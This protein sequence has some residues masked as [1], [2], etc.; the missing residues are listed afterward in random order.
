M[1]DPIAS[2]VGYSSTQEWNRFEYRDSGQNPSV[3]ATIMLCHA[4]AGSTSTLRIDD[5]ALETTALLGCALELSEYWNGARLLLDPGAQSLQNVSLF[6]A[7][8]NECGANGEM[9]W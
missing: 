4:P 3:G 6:G 5:I 9:P 7:E 8:G 2:A 1:S